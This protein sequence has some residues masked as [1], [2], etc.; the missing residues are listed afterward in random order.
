MKKKFIVCYWKDGKI[1][2]ETITITLFKEETKN[3]IT[4]MD[5]LAYKAMQV[6]GVTPNT[7][8]EIC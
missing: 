6:I 3:F 4:R 2:Q 5:Y 7:M 1:Q 8:S